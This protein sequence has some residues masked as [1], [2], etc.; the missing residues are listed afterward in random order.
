MSQPESRCGLGMELCNCAEKFFRRVQSRG[1]GELKKMKKL[2]PIE[3]NGKH[4]FFLPQL[5][6]SYATRHDSQRG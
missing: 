6:L 1:V 4:E 5:R 3:H 2:V